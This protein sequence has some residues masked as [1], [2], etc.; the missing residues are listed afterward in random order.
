LARRKQS[1]YAALERWQFASAELIRVLRLDPAALVDPLEPPH[2]RVSLISIEYAI[3]TLIPVGLRNRPELASQ[4]ALIEATLTRL[5]QERIRPLIPSLALR[6]PGTLSPGAFT[7]GVFGG[8]TGPLTNYAGRSD[9]E[10]QVV[11]EFQNLLLGNRAK[12]KE[13]QAEN[14]LALLEHFRLQDRIAAEI[15][16][17][18][19]QA[20]SAADRLAEAESGLKDATES[21]DKNFQG[22]SQTRRAGDL[23]LLLVRPQ[24]VVAAIQALSQAYGDYYGAIADYNRAQFRLYRAL[25]YPAHF[26]TGHQSACLGPPR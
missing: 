24:E 17:A 18:Q 7:G 22:L 8:G 19:A 26:V 12:I 4:Q 13:R 6:G 20:R 14:Q 23:V 5:K 21:V 9:I 10:L 3:D 25:G 1:A 11:W 15:A 16:Q 2:L